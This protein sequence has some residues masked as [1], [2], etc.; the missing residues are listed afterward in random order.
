VFA[1][2]KG[3]KSEP[4]QKK[5]NSFSLRAEFGLSLGM[6][7]QPTG[8]RKRLKDRSFGSP[9]GFHHGSDHTLICSG[10]DWQR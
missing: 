7:R 3:K 6:N 8:L 2:Y 10:A 5:Q 9:P 4:F 1:S